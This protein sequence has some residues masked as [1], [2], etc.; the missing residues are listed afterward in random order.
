MRNAYLVIPM[1]IS[2]SHRQSSKT[3]LHILLILASVLMLGPFAFML[4]VSL[5]PKEAFMSRSFPLEQAT[6]KLAE[7]ASSGD[8]KLVAAGLGEVGGACK[9]CHD[10]YKAD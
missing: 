2:T 6:V 9:A 10:K 4:V 7:A 3:W 8:P 5:W 1:A